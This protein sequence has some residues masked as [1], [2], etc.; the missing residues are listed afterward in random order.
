MTDTIESLR[1]ELAEL[2]LANKQIH[3]LGKDMYREQESLRA[4]LVAERERT[5]NAEASRETWIEAARLAT[6]ERDEE[7]E[8]RE[9]AEAEAAADYD[10][11]GVNI[12]L[13]ELGAP[14]YESRAENGRLEHVGLNNG[15]RI[16]RLFADRDRLLAIEREARALVPLEHHMHESVCSGC[17]RIVENPHTREQCFA[18]FRERLD[19]AEA[20]RDRLA[21]EQVK[22]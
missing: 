7:R 12:A 16:R 10:T 6:R 22:K 19:E 8:R 20:E 5:I 15:E 17:R 14:A 18:V 2:Q 1:T 9:R 4:E 13:E 11:A 3:A 21:L